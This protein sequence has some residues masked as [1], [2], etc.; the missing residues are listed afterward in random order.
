MI[1]SEGAGFNFAKHA[2]VEIDHRVHRRSVLLNGFL[3]GRNYSTVRYLLQIIQ[4][5]VV[6]S[7]QL[8]VHSISEMFTPFVFPKLKESSQIT[9]NLP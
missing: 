1:V 2:I 4:K 5:E 7:K 9:T 3:E 8:G 6:P